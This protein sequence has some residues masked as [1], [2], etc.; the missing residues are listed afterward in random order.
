MLVI[1]E[2]QLKA[3]SRHLRARF[4]SEACQH[5]QR[6]FPARCDALG[7]QTTLDTVRD[8]LRRA[9]A[10]GFE[11][12]NDLLRYLNLMFEF[13]LEFEALPTNAWARP[14]LD[15]ASQNPTLWMDQLMKEALRRLHPPE[16]EPTA[17]PDDEEDAAAF[18]GL[19]WDAAPVPPDY[20]PTSIKPE[21]LPPP[22]GSDDDDEDEGEPAID[23]EEDDL[24]EDYGRR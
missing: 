7:R 17:D 12:R 9:H 13:G 21:R 1:R 15:R 22:T 24:E 23:D 11:T 3:F 6:Y 4:E 19:V 5:V 14:Y 2:E 8:G 16:P 10:Y 20:V 18:D